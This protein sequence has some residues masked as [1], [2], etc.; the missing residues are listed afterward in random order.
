MPISQPNTA[1]VRRALFVS[2]SV[3]ALAFSSSALAQLAT[4][5]AADQSQSLPEVLVTSP[6]TVPTPESDV[7]SSISVITSQQMAAQQDRTVP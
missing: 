4:G 7:A 3:I 2:S 6:T 1:A 5:Q